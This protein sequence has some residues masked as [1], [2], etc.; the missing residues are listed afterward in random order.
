MFWNRFE[1]DSEARFRG[2]FAERSIPTLRFALPVAIII[3]LFFLFWDYAVNPVG[4]GTT[5]A[6][7]LYFCVLV[8]VAFGFTYLRFSRRWMRAIM[9]GTIIL[10]ATG[11]ILSV[12]LVPEGFRIGTS[13]ILI[14][15]TFACGLAR[16]VFWSAAVVCVRSIAICEIRRSGSPLVDSAY[17]SKNFASPL[18]LA[19]GPCSPN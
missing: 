16:L 7:R 5:L 13:V 6:I 19:P 12:F 18:Y 14:A 4:L 3:Y 1:P 17:T 15:V 2:R 10:G 11:I 8:I 9:C